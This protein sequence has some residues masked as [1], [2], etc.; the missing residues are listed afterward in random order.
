M[1]GSFT[2]DG[3]SSDPLLGLQQGHSLMHI[4]DQWDLKVVVQKRPWYQCWEKW[5]MSAV[6]IRGTAEPFPQK[7][8]FILRMQIT[9]LNLLC[10]LRPLQPYP[11]TAQ[12]F[13]L[14]PLPALAIHPHS[15][16]SDWWLTSPCGAFWSGQ[17]KLPAHIPKN[18]K[19]VCWL[20]PHPP[21]THVSH[22]SPP[23]ACCGKAGTKASVSMCV[24]P[25]TATETLI[26]AKP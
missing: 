26:W 7:V 21:S 11:Q 15:Y 16:L 1:W 20:L 10:A 17:T 9:S 25:F 12:A 3:H 22:S 14:P 19:H 13:F 6:L 4:T 5:C 24:E 23:V 18:Q 2:W 8:H